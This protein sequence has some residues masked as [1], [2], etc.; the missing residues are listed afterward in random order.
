MQSYQSYRHRQESEGN[1]TKNASL[2]RSCGSW[3]GFIVD[4]ALSTSHGVCAVS[5]RSLFR[6]SHSVTETNAGLSTIHPITLVWRVANIDVIGGEE[7]GASLWTG[8]S[9]VSKEPRPFFE[10]ESSERGLKI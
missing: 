4:W 5:S 9:P 10:Q 7:M 8:G 2:H 6:K 1:K 3:E